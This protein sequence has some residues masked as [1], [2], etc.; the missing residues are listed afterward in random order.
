M[1]SDANSSDSFQG[2]RGERKGEGCEKSG[3]E[4]KNTSMISDYIVY[5]LHIDSLVM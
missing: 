2:E 5:S 1:T 3:G 4:K